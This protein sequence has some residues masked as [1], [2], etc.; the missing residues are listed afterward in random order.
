LKEYNLAR[1]TSNA[2]YNLSSYALVGSVDRINWKTLDKQ[3]LPQI[4]VSYTIY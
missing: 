3:D 4:D 2:T 1:I